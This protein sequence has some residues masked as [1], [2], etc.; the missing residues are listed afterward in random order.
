MWF[1]A[2][3]VARGPRVLKRGGAARGGKE[4]G[5]G[6]DGDSVTV[7]H[8]FP[9]LGRVRVVF[10][11]Q[12][13]RCTCRLLTTTVTHLLSFFEVFVSNLARVTGKSWFAEPAPAVAKLVDLV[14]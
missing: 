3:A 11:A 5:T 4:D 6:V 2:G 9:I 8:P 10:K 13:G 14:N 7:G 1:V 12:R